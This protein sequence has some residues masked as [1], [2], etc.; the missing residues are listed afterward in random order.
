MVLELVIGSQKKG[1]KTLEKAVSNNNLFDFFLFEFLI[2]FA[3]ILLNKNSHI[4]MAFYN[5]ILPSG[6]I[7]AITDSLVSRN[8]FDK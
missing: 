3:E 6:L 4:D 1:D 7:A 5:G 2:E 8:L